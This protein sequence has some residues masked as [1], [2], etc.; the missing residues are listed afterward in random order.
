MR[1]LA[2]TAFP[3]TL[4]IHFDHLGPSQQQ[5]VLVAE[6]DKRSKLKAKQMRHLVCE[7]HGMECCQIELSTH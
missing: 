7:Y 5:Q 4:S 3:Q 2:Q 6:L 1:E